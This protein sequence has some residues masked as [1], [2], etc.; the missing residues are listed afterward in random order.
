MRHARFV[1]S[2]VLVLPWPALFGCGSGGGP[3]AP[4]SPMTVHLTSEA[5]AEGGSIPKQ[6]TCDGENVSPPLAWTGLPEG[7]KSLALLVE[8]PDA[9]VGTFTHWIVWGLDPARPGLPQGVKPDTDGM[10]Q[11]RNDFGKLSY[12]GPCPPSGTHRYVFRIYALDR[13]LKLG[14][15]HPPSRTELLQALHGAVLAQ[16]V[17]TG[18]YQR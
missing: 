1:R 17:L 18:T 5:F 6:F 13:E 11:G 14:A 12:G 15:Q 2:L 8:D 7:T 4:D 10:T 9:P 3:P 16:G